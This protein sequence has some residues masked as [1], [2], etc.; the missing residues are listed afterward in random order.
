MVYSEGGWGWKTA[1]FLANAQ[2]KD[3][4][5]RLGKMLLSVICT[6]LP[7]HQ[8]Q[9]A[10][11]SHLQIRESFHL[12]KSKT[13]NLFGARWNAGNSASLNFWVTLA[14]G[15]VVLPAQG[16]IWQGSSLLDRQFFWPGLISA[17]A[18]LRKSSLIWRH[19]RDSW[20]RAEL[21]ERSHM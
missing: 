6:S 13:V 10:R 11:Y 17:D 8:Q 14:V 4:A 15:L 1:N 16:H 20:K 12:I 21:S 9:I 19:T 2:F 3:L 18:L 7:S 5:V